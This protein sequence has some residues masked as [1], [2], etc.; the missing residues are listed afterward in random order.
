[1]QAGR[2]HL[3][4]GFDQQLQVEAE[5]SAPC[6]EHGLERGKVDA[7][8][9]FVIGGAASVPAIA[10]NGDLPRRQP[11]APLRVVAP[12]N[13]AMPVGQAC[14]QGG[15]LVAMSDQEWSSTL[16]GIVDQPGSKA[17]FG[18]RRRH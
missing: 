18:Q 4:T 16:R 6:I 10:R 12:Y 14:R 1:M 3:F 17:E 7:V 11:I 5:P 13:V 2:A 15:P 9:A 8:L